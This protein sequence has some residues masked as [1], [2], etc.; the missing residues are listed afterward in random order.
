MY[1]LAEGCEIRKSKTE[2]EESEEAEVG[3]F[4]G[5][6]LLTWS[7]LVGGKGWKKQKTAVEETG[8]AG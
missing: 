2:T 5:V 8:D 3:L 1:V 4:I 7:A 6:T